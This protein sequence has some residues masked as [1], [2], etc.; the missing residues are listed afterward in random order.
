VKKSPKGPWAIIMI[1]LLLVAV[2]LIL[3][4]QSFKATEKA[5]FDEFNQRQLVLARGAAGGIELYFETL[6]GDVRALGRRPEVQHL[7][8]A[9]T[10]RE[11]QHTFDELEPLGVN[12]VGVL[13]A[14]GVLRYNAVAPQIEGDDFSWRRYYQEAKRL[15]SSD[16]YIIE[17]IEFKGVE[18]GQKGVLV[19][20]PLFETATDENYPAPSSQFAGVV[21]CTL[22]LDTITRKFVAPIQSSER[23]HAF[24]IDDEYNVLW[25][26]DRSLFGK[27]LLEEGKGFPA[28]QQ[29]VE[30][31]SAG[32][33]GAAEYSYY[34]FEDSASEYTRD[35]KEEKLI[36]YAPLYLGN[37]LWAIGV[38]APQEDARQLI[39]SVYLGQLLVVGL[40]ILIIYLGSS[41][42]LA[43]FYR[44]SK[45]L[46]KEVEAK[47]GELKESHERLL[48]VLDSLEAA[49]AFRQAIIDGVAEPIMVIG[50]DYRVQLMNRAA[51]EFSSA[52]ADA[53]EPLLCHQISHQRGTP[54]DGI[55]HPCPLEQ[56]RQ[57]GQPVTVVHE[58]YQANGERRLVEII[59]SPLW[60]ADG[61][62]QG[63]IESVRDITERKRAEEALQQYTERLRA[64]AAQLAEVAE[65]ERQRL[66][67]ELHDQ[68]G[69]NLTAL[70][71]N[72]NIIRTQMSEEAAAP[73]RS[74]LDDSLSLVEQTA[75]R[76][77]D[78]M[79]DLRP[80]VLDDYGLVAAL[81]WYGEQFA[82]RTDIAVVVEGVE[83]VP[84]L[85][86]RVENALFRIAQEALTNVAKHAQATHVTV[87]V[88]VDSGTLRLVVADD[89]I[90]F[91]PSALLR[92]GPAH[93]AQPDGSRGWGLL[94]MTERAEAV[95]GRCCFE[96]DPGQG[97]QVIVEVAQ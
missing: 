20:V 11:I 89:G 92:A 36:A 60:E 7:D 58:H 83:P 65:A 14:N 64:L 38:W 28:F 42:A 90:G 81:H 82:R 10:R 13:D 78:V 47:T 39:R 25:S 26:P 85:A 75:A 31:M 59:A 71:I 95:G 63:I 24:L 67:R 2:I 17:F 49:H 16:T 30:R 86:A 27:N 34:E 53:S 35:K 45:L 50:I 46:E 84:R 22:K 93:L 37:E 76:I 48:T 12:D 79:A 18:A 72:L 8:E 29:I 44:T 96:S 91:D 87:T 56:V 1:A 57:S 74:R 33:S 19:A 54:C 66:A 52:G 51:R 5:T 15:T 4:N 32:D 77:R 43:M 41:Y 3:G 23:G 73:V 61:T 97:A 9:P 69:Q 62:F 55:E 6:A 68:V 80:P 40:S 88:E 70:G 94:T 21:L